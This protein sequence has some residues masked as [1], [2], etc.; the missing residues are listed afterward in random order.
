MYYLKVVK[1]MLSEGKLNQ[2]EALN[3]IVAVYSPE[4]GYLAK[5]GIGISE[6]GYEI[7][8]ISVQGKYLIDGSKTYC[9][10]RAAE[11]IS[12]NKVIGTYRNKTLK[13]K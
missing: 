1:D 11:V 12:G 2:Q 9:L 7:Y 3:I 8:K 13:T 10:E 4:D 5:H 6:N